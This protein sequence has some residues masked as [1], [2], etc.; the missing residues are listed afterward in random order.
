MYVYLQTCTRV[1]CCTCMHACAYMY[2]HVHIQCQVLYFAGHSS[3]DLSD[4]EAAVRPPVTSSTPETAAGETNRVASSDN[5]FSKAL[6]T[7]SDGVKS[8]NL[9][10]SVQQKEV[11][12][13]KDTC[14]SVES[15]AMQQEQVQVHVEH[16]TISPIVNISSSSSDAAEQGALNRSE[17]STNLQ[18][19][20]PLPLEEI[21]SLVANKDEKDAVD[22]N[23]N[24]N[25]VQL[26]EVE[27]I[28][29]PPSSAESNSMFSPHTPSGS[30]SHLGGGSS[31]LNSKMVHTDSSSSLAS[32]GPFSPHTPQGSPS[33]GNT[34]VHFLV[35]STAGGITCS[36]GGTG[37][38][39]NKV[40]GGLNFAAL[41][42]KST[43]S[44]II[45]WAASPNKFTVSCL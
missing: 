37:V 16:S 34:P 31:P 17:N 24:N 6:D 25:S 40:K 44:V 5:S 30:P 7:I 20:S 18:A 35:G 29:T 8:V 9:S 41:E 32:S 4:V 10:E 38:D 2:I 1:M 43:V 15:E 11:V 26:L 42:L 19:E 12:F 45:P 13:T 23:N 28:L 21:A 22:M 33:V 27:N 3:S 39:M 14:N 36:N